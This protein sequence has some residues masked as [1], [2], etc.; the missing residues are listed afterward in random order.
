M[1]LKVQLH[2]KHM[3]PNTLKAIHTFKLEE[4]VK[5]SFKLGKKKKTSKK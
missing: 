5:L 4:K 1:E 2:F 3:P